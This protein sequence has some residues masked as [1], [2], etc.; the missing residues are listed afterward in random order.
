MTDYDKGRRDALEDFAKWADL[1]A[2]GC[3]EEA[4]KVKDNLIQVQR[5]M[6]YM[7]CAGAARAMKGPE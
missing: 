7:S 2:S 5:M 1:M 3:G 6:I 4:Q